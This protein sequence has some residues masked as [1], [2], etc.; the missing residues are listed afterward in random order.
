MYETK[1]DA[2]RVQREM[3]T[4]CMDSTQG[5]AGTLNGYSPLSKQSLVERVNKQLDA[6][7]SEI[8][9]SY[10]LHELAVLLNKHP[11]VARILDLLEEV[12]Y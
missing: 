11:E 8:N 2:I 6:S 4:K 7:Q 12:K 1:E 10:K 5:Q 9:R 3:E